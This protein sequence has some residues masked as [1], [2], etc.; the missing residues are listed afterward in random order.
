[1]KNKSIFETPNPTFLMEI[2]GN[3]AKQ[4]RVYQWV[5]ICSTENKVPANPFDYHH[6]PQQNNHLGVYSILRHP[7]IHSLLAQL[8][9]LPTALFS[10]VPIAPFAR[11]GRPY[12]RC[13][14]P[15][16]ARMLS[17]VCV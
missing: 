9:A 10:Y 1:M 16:C 7:Q 14:S 12:Q 4:Q 13:P 5:W 11:T 17:C 15:V 6:F 3:N 8:V 2:F